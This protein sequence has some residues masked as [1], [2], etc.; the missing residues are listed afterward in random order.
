ME[1][2]AAQEAPVDILLIGLGSIG[3]VFAYLLERV[4]DP[5]LV[6]YMCSLVTVWE[7]S[8]DRRG[9]IKLQSIH[10]NRCDFRYRSIRSHP[11]LAT[12]PGYVPAICL[13]R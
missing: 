11:Q 5:I 10:Q 9:E 6:P 2:T 13:G 3:S 1:V 4:S 12:V 8:S 7:S